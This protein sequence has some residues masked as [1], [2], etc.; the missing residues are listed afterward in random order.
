[1]GLAI[2]R[3]FFAFTRQFDDVRYATGREVAEEFAPQ[4]V[5]DA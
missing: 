1:M 3:D 4:Q 5:G 2:R